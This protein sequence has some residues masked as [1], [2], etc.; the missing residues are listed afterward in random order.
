MAAFEIRSDRSRM[1]SSGEAEIS[2]QRCKSLED[3]GECGSYLLNTVFFDWT[4]QYGMTPGRAITAV[5]LVWLGCSV[6]YFSLILLPGESGLYR[7][8][9]RAPQ[10]DAP[11]RPRLRSAPTASSAIAPQPTQRVERIVPTGNDDGGGA[12]GWLKRAA[13]EWAVFRAAM[14][15]SLM[16]AFNIGFQQFDFGR[17]LR[18]LSRQ[19]F[20]IKAVGWARVVAGW[21]SLVSVYL[22]ALWVL[23]YFG[24]PFG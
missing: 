7:I 17:W 14:F 9:P 22:F 20:D 21:Q 16:S 13:A 18:L 6:I 4:S 2:W 12:W 3:I 15:F 1:R 8:Y 24:R 10:P 23:S 11:S 5:F 19:D